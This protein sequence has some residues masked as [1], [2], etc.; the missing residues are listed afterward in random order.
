MTDLHR[1]GAAGIPQETIQ[2]LIRESAQ[3]DCSGNGGVCVQLLAV[4]D[5]P[6][7]YGDF[8]V[9]A[10]RS[11]SDSK[12]HAALVRGNVVGETNVPVRLH[13]ECL[14]GDGFGS[15]RCDCREQLES[16][17]RQLGRKKAGV[18]LY[19]RQEGRGIGF[20]NKIRAYQ[21]QEAGLDTVQAN[22][23]LGFAADERD[24]AV[25]AHMLACLKVESIAL[26][27]NNP[28]KIEDLRVHG[29]N[30]VQRIPILVRPN[31]FNRR[32]LETK[33]RRLGHLLEL[34]ATQAFAEQMDSIRSGSG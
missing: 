4:A 8:Q 17:L 5:L 9:V 15:L 19:L 13:S 27:S 7:L 32:Y 34:T 11:P 30:V 2:E 18:I 3:H 28:D 6:T 26:M 1:E 20:A 33:E 22:Q 29:V 23:A 31:R 14:T 21:L 12:E 10:F 25:A 16:S 24:Y